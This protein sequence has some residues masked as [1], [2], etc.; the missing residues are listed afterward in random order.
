MP[1]MAPIW[2]TILFIMFNFSFLSM[3]TVMYFQKEPIPLMGKEVTE[4]TKNLNW[5]W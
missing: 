3:I 4:K 1:Q 2:W 5:K